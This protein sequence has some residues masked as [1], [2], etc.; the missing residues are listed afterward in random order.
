M[1]TI[2]VIKSNVDMTDLDK[3]KRIALRRA[4]V[5]II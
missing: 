4:I 5:L 1:I 3:M 2:S